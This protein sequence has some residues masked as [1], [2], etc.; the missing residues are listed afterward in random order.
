MFENVW[1]T[2]NDI[3]HH[4]DSAGYRMAD[5]HLTEE[6]LDFKHNATEYL[7][8]GD[9]SKIDHPRAEIMRWTKS[10]KESMLNMLRKWRR[11]HQVE[12]TLN[13]KRQRALTK[14]GFTAERRG[15]ADGAGVLGHVTR[16]KRRRRPRCVRRG[17]IRT[18]QRNLFGAV[19]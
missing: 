17:W 4:K 10:A 3:L 12:T 14:Y 16:T 1:A 18:P 9:R 6:L 13:G 5:R 19:T 2:R 15:G 11:Q 7:H 8:Y